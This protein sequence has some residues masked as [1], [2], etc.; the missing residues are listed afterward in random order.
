M[1]ITSVY[2]ELWKINESKNQKMKIKAG[3]MQIYSNLTRQTL[4]N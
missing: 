4:K 1:F 2:Y 3:G